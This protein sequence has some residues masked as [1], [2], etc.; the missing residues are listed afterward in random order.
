MQ[1][2]RDRA[3]LQLI[4]TLLNCPN[5]HEPQIL[6]DNSELLDRGFLETCESVAAKLAAQGGENG[7]NFLRNLVSHLGQF[8]DMNDDGDS[9]N[10]QGENPQEYAKFILELL[11][12][13]QASKGDIKVIYPML[14]GRQHLL[15]ARFAETLQQVAQRLLDGENAET[16]SSIVSLLENLSI[17][18]SN[19]PR[20]NRANNIEIA[21][22]GYQIVSNN[23]EPGK[24]DWARTQNN[25]G[26]SYGK[27]IRGKK[28]ENIEQE[29]GF[30]ERALT[31]YTLED[32]PE[33]WAWTQNNLA[34]AYTDRIN[35]LRAENLERAIGFCE[36]TL[37]VYTLE[38]FPEKWAMIQ[39]N[40]A[41]AYNKRINGSRAENLER[42]IG[43][44]EAAL[45]VR[46]LDDFPEDWAETQNNLAVAYRNRINGS[47][48]ENLERAIG[49]HEATLRVRTLENFPQD[50]ALIQHNLA[51]TYFH[52]IKGSQD[53][54][55]GRAIGFY[56]AALTVYTLQDFPEQWAM[57][58]NSLANA[59]SNRNTVYIFK[60][61]EDWVAETQNNLANA[62]NQIINGSRA[63]NL[64]QAIGFY[65][66]AL[67][68]YTLQDFPKEWA[69]T[70]HNL[71]ITYSN[72]IN[73]SRAENLERAIAFFDAALTVRTLKDFPIDN[74]QT[75]NNLGLTYLVK[76]DYINQEKP[77]DTNQKAATLQ[78]AY[79]TFKN[80][81]LRAS[82]L[83]E[84]ESGDET[85][86]KHDLQWDR[87]YQ[88]MVQVCLD[89]KSN[90]EALLYAEANKARNLAEV[91]AQK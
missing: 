17:R 40:L 2:N 22:A 9:N 69:D 30:Y 14:D 50:W 60:D 7:A 86:Q 71:A 12:A 44:C 5:G 76:L 28:A 64:E 10:S 49:F 61:L 19:F 38:D 4:H 70:Q 48:V 18:I 47:R 89:R 78:S 1:E 27:R 68:V 65:E 41:N 91:I 16:I 34:A 63:N 81:I 88:G 87:L 21:I 46:T 25:L 20:G 43:F 62:Y 85:K 37:T 42:A 82:K 36:A 23:R 31:V 54:N 11:Q 79:D 73:G 3:Y 51:L 53:Q 66:A 39:Y 26:S 13:Q 55:L 67:T 74:V 52:R 24:E 57:T 58:Q 8:I 56:E 6:Q 75:L 32:F 90:Q 77:E 83:R 35:G 45:T 72:R 29:I 84:L 59:Y 15:N 80:A 33:D